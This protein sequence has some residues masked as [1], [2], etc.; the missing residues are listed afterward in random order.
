MTLPSSFIYILA[1]IGFRHNPSFQEL[2]GDCIGIF[3]GVGID[4][5]CRS[6]MFVFDKG[7]HIF[8]DIRSG[9]F[10]SDLI[11]QIGTIGRGSK[12]LVL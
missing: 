3:S 8:Q 9:F 10:G 4:N 2:I 1:M 7:S 6:G 12:E 5:P 11:G